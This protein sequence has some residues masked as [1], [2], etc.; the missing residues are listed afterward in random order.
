L[1]VGG[2]TTPE[3][4]PIGQDITDFERLLCATHFRGRLT[5]KA[6]STTM[7]PGFSIRAAPRRT[8]GS[9]RWSWPDTLPCRRPG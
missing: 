4:L 9:C 8:P 5:M 2:L 1:G 3:H 7:P 6:I